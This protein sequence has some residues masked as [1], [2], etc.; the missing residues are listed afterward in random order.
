MGHISNQCQKICYCNSDYLLLPVQATMPKQ[1]AESKSILSDILL[2]TM[3]ATIVTVAAAKKPRPL[4]IS[5]IKYL[6]SD[7]RRNGE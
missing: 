4:L 5:F 6:L 2:V 1:S 7:Y 3:I